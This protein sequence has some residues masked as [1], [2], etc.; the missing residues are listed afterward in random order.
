MVAGWPRRRPARGATPPGGI[1]LISVASGETRA[2]TF[3]KPP[4]FDVDPAFSPDGR[5]LAYASC[6][7]AE[8]PP[9]CDVYVLSL[10]SE[11]AAR[12]SGSPR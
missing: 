8:T 11:L 10:D 6:E 12:G 9:A 5:A 1:Y 7:G 2:V 4:A 3:P